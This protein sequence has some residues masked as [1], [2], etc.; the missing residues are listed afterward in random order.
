MYVTHIIM[1]ILGDD[2]PYVEKPS[3]IQNLAVS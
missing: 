1:L 3:I 2:A